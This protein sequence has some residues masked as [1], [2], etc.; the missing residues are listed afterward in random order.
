MY[1]GQLI[2][3]IIGGVLGIFGILLALSGSRLLGS[4]VNWKITLGLATSG[5]GLF[6]LITALPQYAVG[7]GVLA[8]LVLAL[9]ALMAIKQNEL[10]FSGERNRVVVNRIRNWAE[11]IFDT[12]T[13][14]PASK[15]LDSYL[16]ELRG[17]LRSSSVQSIGVMKDAELIGGE[18][19]GIVK[20][21]VFAIHTLITKAGGA[22]DIARFKSFLQIE[23]Q[24][25]P[26][27]TS[28]EL[29]EDLREVMQKF[30]DLINVCAKYS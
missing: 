5:V 17:N 29:E 3:G 22:E 30:T 23:E 26:I 18:L 15:Q 24:I 10:Q 7:F 19:D 1:S 28:A 27:T 8:T 21:A 16:K 13:S 20:N 11:A 12:I 14:P 4:R 2:E 25:D 9:A 6:V